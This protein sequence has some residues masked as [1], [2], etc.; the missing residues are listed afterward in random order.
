[1]MRKTFWITPET[2]G[3]PIAPSNAVADYFPQSSSSSRLVNARYQ[4]F[5]D[6]SAIRK[7]L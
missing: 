5:M 7:K 2:L 4:T 3:A 1:M 6:S